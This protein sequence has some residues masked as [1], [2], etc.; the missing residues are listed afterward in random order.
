VIPRV[1]SVEPMRQIREQI[2][3]RTHVKAEPY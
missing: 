1:Q 2:R 3:A